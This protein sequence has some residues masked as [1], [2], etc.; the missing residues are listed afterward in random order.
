MKQV[1]SGVVPGDSVP[2]V[3]V[4][5]QLAPITNRKAANNLLHRVKVD[6]RIILSNTRNRCNPIRLPR[7]HENRRKKYGRH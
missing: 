6:S 4:D 1:R 2:A 3:H 7:L 5:L